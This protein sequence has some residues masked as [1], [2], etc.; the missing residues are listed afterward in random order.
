MIRI[1]GK[2]FLCGEYAVLAGAPAVLAAVGPY[3]TVA[4]DA[5]AGALSPFV[6]AALQRASVWLAE[7][8]KA[9][10][11]GLPAINTD[12]FRAEDGKKLGLGSSAVATVG[13]LAAV[14]D[15][16]GLEVTDPAVRTRLTALAIDAHRAAQGGT[17][18][19]ADIATCV[20][21]GFIRYVTG[22]AG[23]QVTA[24]RPP[25]GLMLALVWSGSSASTSSMVGQVRRAGAALDQLAVLAHAFADA[26]AG[27]DPAAVI[28]AAKCYGHAL[29]TL[30]DQAGV[31]VV[32]RAFERYM[33]IAERQGGAAKPSGAGGGDLG[34]AFLPSAEAAAAVARDA[35]AEGLVP[36]ELGWDVGGVRQA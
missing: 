21:G 19:G 34:V 31:P 26:F 29:R 12:A 6:E 7:L 4:L 25:P 22:D 35:V 5:R 30:G 33:A 16:A 36:C 17:G 2:V 24:L 13:A 20:H 23:P 15:A 18:S 8:G 27:D 9:M 14:I 28:A 32:T 3:G 11:V 1:P 10:P